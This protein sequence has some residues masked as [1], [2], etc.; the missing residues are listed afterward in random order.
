MR[1]VLCAFGVATVH[2]LTEYDDIML[3][4][5]PI[6]IWWLMLAL[7]TLIDRDYS[8]TTGTGQRHRIRTTV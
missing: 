7:R 1:T 6:I 5:I 8:F 4:T 3:L 2:S